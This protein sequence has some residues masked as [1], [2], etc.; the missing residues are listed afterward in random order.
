MSLNQK[1]TWK[2]LINLT[3]KYPNLLEIHAEPFQLRPMSKIYNNPEPYGISLVKWGAKVRHMIPELSDIVSKIPMAISGMPKALDTIRRLNLTTNTF[4]GKP[5]SPFLIEEDKKTRRRILGYIKPAYKIR[6]PREYFQISYIKS[7]L[8][9]RD[10]IF[11]LTWNNVKYPLTSE[12]CFMLDHFDGRTPLSEVSKKLSFY[13][14]KQEKICYQAILKFLNDLVD[15]N[16][17]FHIL[18]Q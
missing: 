1:Y 11:I 12:E 5:Y 16:F 18:F 7:K 9:S 15:R 8:K 17:Q 4:G 14:N 6:I 10:N 2:T 3:K 13:F